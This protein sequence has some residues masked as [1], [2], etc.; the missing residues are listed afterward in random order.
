M[1]K[2][3]IRLGLIS[4]Y[5][6][7]E[8]GLAIYTNKLVNNMIKCSNN[9]HNLRIFVFSNRVIKNRQIR[10]LKSESNQ[11][12]LIYPIWSP[13]SIV[14]IFKLIKVIIKK[15]VNIVHLQY[16][17]YSKFGF[18]LGEPLLILTF[19][20]KSVIKIPTIVTLHS[21]WSFIEVYQRIRERGKNAVIA[22]L[23]AIYYYLFMF[24]FL[25]LFTR[26][27]L[28]VNFKSSRFTSYI[29]RYFKLPR[30]KV[31]EI[32]HGTEDPKY[33]EISEGS[34]AKSSK[35]FSV[36]CF[37]FIRP[38]K[39]YE[40]AIEALDYIQNYRI[41]LIIA[42]K[43]ITLSDY[44]YLEFLM[45]LVKNRALE[46]KVKIISHFLSDYEIDNLF[47]NCDVLLLP[48]IRRVGPS[49]PIA[50][51]TAYACP[52]IATYDNK[53]FGDIK[54]EFILYVPPKNSRAIAKAIEKLIN[55]SSLYFTLRKKALLY[56]F[57]NTFHKVAKIHIEIYKEL[58]K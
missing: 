30:N 7:D 43:P 20:L 33:S 14:S 54:E 48:Y 25:H 3:I 10:D 39:G 12:V 32:I 58:L 28:C 57:K 35:D 45:R 16:G 36:L 56:S 46:N 47:R 38:D 22:Y 5:P 51:A 27:L 34:R 53:F 49:G 8:D 26:V 23:G 52:I 11:K 37:G 13:N 55:N 29:A 44:K 15:R 2:D 1:R 4:P 40:Y 41:K 42:G 21:I 6:P 24:I 50:Y 31:K 9:Q 17:P 19:I 18:L